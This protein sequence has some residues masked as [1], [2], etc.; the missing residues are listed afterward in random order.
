V[1]AG[2]QTPK[3]REALDEVFA[4]AR[5][6]LNTAY[7]LLSSV[8][9]DIRPAFLMLAQAKRDLAA[10]TRADNDPFLARPPSRFRTLW[11]LWRASRSRAF[12]F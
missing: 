4:E 7:A 9:P 1:F 2:R 12:V 8:T 5:T 10:L 3:L 11:T 6:H